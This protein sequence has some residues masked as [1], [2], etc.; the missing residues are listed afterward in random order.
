MPRV[1][2]RAQMADDIL[3]RHAI[4]HGESTTYDTR[5]N[6]CRAMSL[7][8]YVAWVVSYKRQAQRDDD[9]ASTRAEP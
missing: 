6:S 4:L 3:N 5:L 2:N 8:V 1:A 9:D 7:L